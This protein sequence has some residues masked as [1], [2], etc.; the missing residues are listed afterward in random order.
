MERIVLALDVGGTKLAAGVV[1]ATGTVHGFARMPTAVER[2]PEPVLADLFTLGTRVLRE[3]G[4]S[5]D[6]LAGIGI[7]CGG[8][9]DAAAGVVYGPPP[10]LPGWNRVPLTAAA[11]EAFGR[12]AVL[13][14]DAT[15]AALGEYRF[16]DWGAGSLAYVTISTGVGG[17]LVLGGR[18]FAGAVGNGGEPGHVLVDWRGRACACG[19]RGCAEAYLSGPSIARRALEALA[20]TDEP[21]QLR[22]LDSVT[23]ADVS[24]AA[25]AGDPVAARVWAE[26]VQ[27]LGGWLAGLVNVWEPEL[28]VLGGGVTRAGERLLL[29]PV[30]ELVRQLAMPAIA[31]RVEVVVSRSDDRSG[32]LGAAALA[33]AAA[34]DAEHTPGDSQLTSASE[35]PAA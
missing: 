33:L 2:G 15:A 20:G 22:R 16:G 18:P 26:T 29:A 31:R 9:L 12:P 32:V 30:R 19:A 21:S 28:V 10:N 6:T 25:D 27:I 24:A 11:S 8:P 7:S 4:R 17:G 23:A 5:A 1:D 34:E 3:A 35:G 14:N 13:A